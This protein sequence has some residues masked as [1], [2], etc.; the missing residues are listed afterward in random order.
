MNK[1]DRGILYGMSLGDGGIYITKDQSEHTARMVIGHS[2]KQREYLEYKNKLL[3]SIFGGKLNNINEYT[4]LNKRM[5]K[6]YTNVQVCRTEK[7]FRQMHRVLYQ[8][9]EK[10]YTEQVLSYLTDH[11]LAL[12]YMDDGSGTVC[13]N[14]LGNI[15]GCMTRIATYCSYEEAELLRSWFKTKYDLDVKF[16]IDKRNDK[17][18]IRFNTKDSNKFVQTVSPYIHDSMKYKIEHVK[19]YNPRVPSPSLEGEDIV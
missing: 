15:S 19:E 4:S 9:G 16:D 10:R 5:N 14:K 2:P 18:S 3:H 8:T 1:I 6:S 11:G 12:W 13:K 7:Y 17:V